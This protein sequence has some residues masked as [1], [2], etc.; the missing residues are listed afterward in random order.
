MRTKTIKVT[1]FQAGDHIVWRAEDRD[2]EH[3]EEGIDPDCVL[4][5]TG[6]TVRDAMGART[7]GYF[8]AVWSID[9]GWQFRKWVDLPNTHRF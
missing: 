6:G 9:E 2:G 3:V 5:L 7:E 4:R 1:H 8:T